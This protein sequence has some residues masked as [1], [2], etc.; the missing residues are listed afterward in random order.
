MTLSS[1]LALTAA[2]FV[3]ALTPGPGV[4]VTKSAGLTAS[5]QQIMLLIAG[6][7]TGD[8]VFLML[9]LLVLAESLRTFMEHF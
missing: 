6:I 4:F 7:I 2:M 3:L 1:L 8:I 9:S 5:R